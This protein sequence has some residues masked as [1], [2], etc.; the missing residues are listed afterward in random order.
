MDK[1]FLK[2]ISVNTKRDTSS[3]AHSSKLSSKMRKSRSVSTSVLG[4]HENIKVLSGK[5][6][7]AHKKLLTQN[8]GASSIKDYFLTFP[9]N[10]C[11]KKRKFNIHEDNIQIAKKSKITQ[12]DAIDYDG[13]SSMYSQNPNEKYWEMRSEQQ[14]I[15]LDE[16]LKENEQLANDLTQKDEEIKELKDKVEVLEETS[17]YAYKL[18]SYL[19][20][21]DLPSE[22]KRSL[23]GD[24]SSPLKENEDD[25]D[26]NESIGSF[27]SINTTFSDI[28][29]EDKENIP[30]DEEPSTSGQETVKISPD[31]IKES[32]TDSQEAIEQNPDYKIKESTT[33]FN[34]N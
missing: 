19:E 2:S 13:L 18:A 10:D 28:D 33:T 20:E 4:P 1:S 23:N 8:K 22:S 31:N 7:F 12:T 21:L 32:S 9:K 25:E 29:D 16:A 14:R 6:N 3:A 5:E 15:A 24:P 30:P 27:Q 11:D 34:F 26:C 17:S